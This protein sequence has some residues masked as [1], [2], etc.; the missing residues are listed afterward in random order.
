MRSALIIFVGFLMGCA[1]QPEEIGASYVSPLHYKNFDCEQLEMEAERVS[2]RAFE[3]GTSLRDEADADEVQMAVGLI[4][5]WPTLF[6]L[7]GG[8][9]HRSMEYS[10]LKGERNAIESISIQKKCFIAFKPL[11]LP[12]KKEFKDGSQQG[13]PPTV[14][15][16]TGTKSPYIAETRP[17]SPP[18]IKNN[19]K[20]NKII[21]KR[22]TPA[23][24]VFHG[25]PASRKS[26]VNYS[27]NELQTLALGGNPEGQFILGKKY[28]D[29]DGVSK[30]LDRAIYY[31][32][33]ASN[34]QHAQAQLTLGII[35][36]YGWGRAIDLRQA[37]HWFELARQNG[38]QDANYYLEKL[39]F[40]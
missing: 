22:N 9:D 26:F 29:G 34:Q 16:P 5:L 3:L 8:D 11:V 30:N 38:D 33:A 15:P 32:K 40:N 27:L 18:L 4:L 39:N 37:K 13:P 21:G 24:P 36:F 7:E 23:A 14:T 31:L 2:R 20:S 35:F 1:T 10:R 25:T 6:W 19:L 17:V 12:K 28:F